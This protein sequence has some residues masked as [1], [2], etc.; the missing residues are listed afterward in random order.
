MPTYVRE[1]RVAAPLDD[2][3][4]FHSTVD[5]LR[6]LTPSWMGLRIEDVT[7][8][9]DETDPETLGPGTE[10]RMSVRPLGLGPRWRWT[11][12]ITARERTGGS[13][14]FRDEM[15][16][17][18]FER[19]EHTHVF[20]GAGDET[21]VRDRLDYATPLGAVGDGLAPLFLE[22]MFRDRHRRTRD[23]FAP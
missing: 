15:R 4:A 7:G 20:H 19:W 13:A 18:P 1:T 12:E 23:R 8:A 6:A 10:I 22:G 16:G 17:G 3:W 11:S 5:G 9:G 21:V 2:V 14:F